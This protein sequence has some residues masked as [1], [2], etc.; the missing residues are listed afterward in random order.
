VCADLTVQGQQHL[1]SE[2]LALADGVEARL[3]RLDIL[4]VTNE[5]GVTTFKDERGRVGAGRAR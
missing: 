4:L 3:H 2:E 1:S 5:L